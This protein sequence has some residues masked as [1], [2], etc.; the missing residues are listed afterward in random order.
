MEELE[1]SVKMLLAGPG[2]GKTTR[3][4]E[5]VGS[6]KDKRFLVL[7]FT[8]ATVKDLLRSFEKD[9][10]EIGKRNCM[11]LH[12]YA[13]RITRTL[14]MCVLDEN[15]QAVAGKYAA[16]FQ[17]SLD[18]FCS[19]FNC[20]TFDQMIRNASAYVRDNTVADD[21]L[22]DRDTIL[23]VDE[24]QDF[25]PAEREFISQIAARASDTYVF[26][27][28]DQCIYDFKNA[29]IEGIQSLYGDPAV[30]KLQHKN[31]CFRC[32]EEVVTAGNNLICN[33]QR[34]VPKQLKSNGKAGRVEILQYRTQAQTADAV[35]EKV[36]RVAEVDQGASIML[37]SS[38]VYALDSVV[39]ALENRG[40]AYSNLL[41]QDVSQDQRDV[42]WEVKCLL[43]SNK[44]HRILYLLFL[45]WSKGGRKMPGQDVGREQ[46]EKSIEQA[47]LGLVDLA[48]QRTSLN[49]RF[50][51]LLPDGAD[52]DALT[53]EL[54][55][56]TILSKI[57]SV[58]R[59]CADMAVRGLT[60][61]PSSNCQFDEHG[62][63]VLTIHKS[64]GLQADYVFILG[65]VEGVLPNASRGLNDIENQ[66]RLLYVGMTR[67]LKGLYLVSTTE[68]SSQV[69]YKFDK[70]KFRFVP[71]SAIR[72]GRASTFISELR[73][74]S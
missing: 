54:R 52:L 15:E 38:T 53:T 74:P 3:I 9:E 23:L 17:M 13:L 29:G 51:E 46:F 1:V 37:L 39:E 71:K 63:N 10:A 66:R 43:S 73:G 21:C 48:K 12:A 40:I 41:T 31:V 45:L 28:D 24:F 22:I 58:D 69:V 26:G 47:W 6:N 16:R 5:I 20:V 4:K 55:Y 34:R 44:K 18:D 60:N 14:N 30:E 67:A 68:W 7:S 50:L 64:K 70:S 56:C 36:Q 27:D 2:T 19:L 25:N 72:L 57:P 61:V 8:N 35:L 32:P 42:L 62:T 33:N 49:A 65:V 59:L 11:T